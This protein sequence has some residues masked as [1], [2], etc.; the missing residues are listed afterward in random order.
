MVQQYLSEFTITEN[1][2]SCDINCMRI[3]NIGWELVLRHK[4]LDK[5]ETGSKSNTIRSTL[6]THT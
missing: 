3:M 5:I 1:N 4:H 2:T 6:S